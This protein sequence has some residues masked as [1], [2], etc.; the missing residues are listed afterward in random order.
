[1]ALIPMNIPFIGKKLQAD[2]HTIKIDVK[3]TITFSQKKNSIRTLNVGG[4]RST[5]SMFLN[6]YLFQ[7]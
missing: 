3:T 5:P 6:L 1:M 7:I 2:L 4:V